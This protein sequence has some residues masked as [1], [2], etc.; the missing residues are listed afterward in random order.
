M[1]A[2]AG[3]LQAASYS[4]SSNVKYSGFKDT[5]SSYRS[6]YLSPAL[7]HLR[8]ALQPTSKFKRNHGNTIRPKKLAANLF[9]HLA[10][11]TDI[12]VSLA[13]M[14]M[15]AYKEVL[16]AASICVIPVRCQQISQARPLP[17]NSFC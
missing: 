15:Q 4:L 1:P 14:P 13:G 2:K 5:L 16:T 12:S 6:T 17:T 3:R 10:G 8:Q 11:V 9:L 7:V